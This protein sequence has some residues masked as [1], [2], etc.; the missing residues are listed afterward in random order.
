MPTLLQALFKPTEVRVMLQAYEDEIGRIRIAEEGVFGPTM[1][2]TIIDG[3]VRDDLTNN[4][5]AVKEAVRSGERSPR[6]LVLLMIARIASRHAASGR[7]LDL[8]LDARRP[9]PGEESMFGHPPRGGARRLFAA[10]SKNGR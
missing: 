8:R 7:Y 3:E 6:A 1:G 9:T 2:L 5:K 10:L 4:P